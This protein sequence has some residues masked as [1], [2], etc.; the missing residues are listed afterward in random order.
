MSPRD[1]LEMEK[2]SQL[3]G[4]TGQISSHNP[5]KNGQLISRG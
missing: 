1:L 3:F 2:F 5:K 4:W